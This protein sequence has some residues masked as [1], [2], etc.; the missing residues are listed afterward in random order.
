[1]GQACFPSTAKHDWFSVVDRKGSRTSA[2]LV[3]ILRRSGLKTTPDSG[4]LKHKWNHTSFPWRIPDHPLLTE[5]TLVAVDANKGSRYASRVRRDI[6]G[7][8]MDHVILGRPLMPGSAFIDVMLGV[9]RL[10]NR[11]RGNR[12]RGSPH[13]CLG[14]RNVEIFSPLVLPGLEASDLGAVPGAFGPSPLELLVESEKGAKEFAVKVSSRRIDALESA[15]GDFEYHARGIVDAFAAFPATAIPLPELRRKFSTL[16]PVDIP[17]LYLHFSR[18]GWQYG[19]GFQSIGQLLLS[20]REALVDLRLPRDILPCEEGFVIHP[21]ILDGLFQA[22]GALLLNEGAFS[23]RST[24]VPVGLDDVRITTPSAVW[25]NVWGH[26][27]LSSVREDLSGR[28][29]A[30][31]NCSVYGPAGT[32][33]VVVTGLR[34][35]PLR[36]TKALSTS[37]PRS[38]LSNRLWRTDWLRVGNVTPRSENNLPVRSPSFWLLA[39]VPSDQLDEARQSLEAAM[40]GISAVCLALGAL[41]SAAD[42]LSVLQQHSWGAVMHI[43]GTTDA[44]SPTECL[45]D[46]LFFLGGVTDWIARRD[47]VEVLPP[48]FLVTRGSQCREGSDEQQGGL[49]AHAGVVGLCR[50]A[51]LEM[52]ALVNRF[53]PLYYVDLEGSLV[54]SHITR[55]EFL[56]LAAVTGRLSEDCSVVQTC[57]IERR[58]PPITCE[59]EVL[60]RGGSYYVPR[61]VPFDG[62]AVVSGSDSAFRRALSGTLVITGGLGD[63]GLV[64][65]NWLAAENARAIVLVSRSGHPSPAVAQSAAWRTLQA[66]VGSTTT[67]TAKCDVGDAK[68]VTALFRALRAGELTCSTTSKAVSLPPVCGIFHAAGV[69]DDRPLQK[70][71]KRSME[72]VFWPKVYGAWN[73]HNVLA[74]LDMN[75]SIH[76]FMMFSSIVGAVGNPGQANYAAANACLD[77]LALHRRRSGLAA[78]SIQWGPWIEQGMA[79]GVAERLR[80]GGLEGIQNR[81]GLETVEQV[82]SQG[83]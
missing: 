80:R 79:V 65:A 81:D 36:P 59:T 41:K 9:G 31:F 74:E 57:A 75:A 19:R 4:A 18:L 56:E 25:T 37:A 58:P 83:I 26:V 39:G 72:S 14:L 13:V 52:E 53:V 46:I 62:G 69:L 43:G 48:M 68:Q 1:M 54:T 30:L 40:P 32:T 49:P 33:C 67:V 38:I 35:R 24:F 45:A 2:E 7:T 3:T 44:S 78:H 12:T 22:A 51:K 50:T 15:G 21:V 27:S 23:E 64:I 8:L 63:I 82:A 70:H 73:L 42:V 76:V 71:D 60:L 16:P 47:Q 5:D 17:G 34:M 28:Q 20:S 77:T 55:G 6:L 11:R 61:F 10:E 29:E 66:R